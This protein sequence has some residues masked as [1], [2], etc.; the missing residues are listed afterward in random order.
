MSEPHLRLVLLLALAALV[1]LEG[2]SPNR[3]YRLAFAHFGPAAADIYVAD[4]DGNNAHPFLPHDALDYNASLSPGGDWVIFTSERN[5]S[6][7]IYRARLDGSGL[8]RL[9]EDRA[10][11]DQA[12]ASP[13]GR[14][15]A[16]VSTRSGQADVWILDLVTKRVRNLTNH[17][18]GDFRPAWSPDGEWIA[19]SSDRDSPH[20][21]A[22]SRINVLHSTEIFIVKKDG[23]SVRQVTTTHAFAGSPAW[24]PEGT[25]LVFFEAG[26]DQVE[27]IASI[28]A[29]EKQLEGITRIVTID[30]Q[31]GERRVVPSREGE[32]VSPAWTSRGLLWTRLGEAGGIEGS[33]AGALARGDF[34]NPKWS[35]DGRRMVFHRESAR[36]LPVVQASFSRD[37]AFQLTRTGI[38]PAYSP[39]GN[40]LVVN[41][42]FFAIVHNR[43]M[44]M[45]ADGSERRVLFEAPD[46][47]ALAAAWSPKGDRI[48]FAL[49]SFFPN[50]MNRGLPVSNLALINE[51][52]SGSRLLTT[53]TAH[54]GFPSWSP[55][56]ARIVYRT[57]GQRGKGLR[58]I[59]VETGA[60]QVL[61]E[62]P[63]NDNFPSW[64]PRGDAIAFTS[65][66]DGDYE[67]YSI[68]PDGTRLTRLTRSP[69]N[70]AHS[71]WSH[72]GEWIAF[73]SARGGFSDEAPLH[74]HNAQ[75]YGQIYVMRPDGR[76]VRRL[77][78][79]QF[80][81]ATPAWIPVSR[82]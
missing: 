71:S 28:T 64:S 29:N 67:L 58:I 35:R 33:A 19:F 36:L 72:D 41:T 23:T 50:T 3:P 40:R 51:D 38:F 2:H 57:A 75:P 22:S 48:A 63:Q 78:D 68:R 45:K 53:G 30:V 11:D 54:D 59:D 74:P 77:T 8:E 17:P 6:A 13:D 47:S 21:L 27:R 55:D 25:Q 46:S 65:N 70:D 37:P 26:L 73:S 18:A 4:G 34:R 7:D 49:G 24:S 15:V 56:G 9:T 39:A 1:P 42:G 61:T 5:G 12:A 52:G 69:G 20:P 43:L 82:P 10:F 62:G 76:D 80:E 60:V 66:R 44:L 81:S 79:S 14:S 31:S 16:F 32:N